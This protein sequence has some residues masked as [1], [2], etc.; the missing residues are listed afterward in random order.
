MNAHQESFLRLED[1]GRII[2][3][4]QPTFEF[5]TNFINEKHEY[6]SK[7]P[8]IE[9]K[10][11]QVRTNRTSG[12]LIEGWLRRED[13]LKIYEMAYFVS[14]DI[15]ELGTY[16]GLSTSIL[17]Q[18]NADSPHKKHIYSVELNFEAATVAQRNLDVAGLQ[19]DVTLL[20]TDA[21]TAIRE[22]A[23]QGKK[24]EFVFIDHSH[25]YE[26]V[27]SVCK[28]LDRIML[29]EGFCLFHDFND[30]RNTH[31]NTDYEVYQG[32]MA[33]LDP[34]EFQF[35]GIY[36]C[37]GLYKFCQTHPSEAQ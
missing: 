26:A 17:S 12:S 21:V 23:D 4:Y 32:V 22:F 19:E 14:G 7:C 9:D 11:I 35:Y 29:A 8:I 28:E 27:F 1:L 6:F 24:F 37:A 10:L 18:A 16:H 13:A 25:S 30:G 31:D 36:G 5:S 34:G 20:V 33:G 2:P 3:S 15:L